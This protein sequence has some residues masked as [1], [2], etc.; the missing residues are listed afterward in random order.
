M[1]ITL[2]D[3]SRRRTIVGAVVV[4]AAVA[5]AVVLV[6]ERSPLSVAVLRLDQREATGGEAEG[7][8][9]RALASHIERLLGDSLS[10]PEAAAAAEMASAMT[11]ALAARNPQPIE[12]FFS[13]IG[14]VPDVEVLEMVRAHLRRLPPR[15]RPPDIALL[16]PA[17]LIRLRTPEAAPLRALAPG[18][19][20]IRY[21][22]AGTMEAPVLFRATKD[23][24]WFV[25]HTARN[26]FRSAADFP[27]RVHALDELEAAGLVPRLHLSIGGLTDENAPVVISVQ[28]AYL[29]PHGWT[30]R[31]VTT[32][33]GA[34][35][36]SGQKFIPKM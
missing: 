5:T 32:Q 20:A 33:Q 26:A 11:V 2:Q 34:G 14:A 22:P 12:A 9:Q 31:R 25:D 24:E 15:R 21:L 4:F 13:S 28:F 16:T 10:A 8:A 36:K 23:R 35:S 30:P 6:R 18:A 17:E 1:P 19:L 27:Y 29:E 7:D 3:R